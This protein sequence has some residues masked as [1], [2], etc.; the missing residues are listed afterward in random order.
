MSITLIV[1]YVITCSHDES[2]Q[3][4]MTVEENRTN[5]IAAGAEVD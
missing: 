3:N 1:G 4:Q 2:E 5:E